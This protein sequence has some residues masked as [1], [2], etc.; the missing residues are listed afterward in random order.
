MNQELAMPGLG[1][2][3][4]AMG[5][6]DNPFPVVPDARHYF[7]T[8][9]LRGIA[10]EVLFAISQRKGFVVV[11]GDV[12]VGKTT[13]SRYLIRRLDGEQYR[14]ALI[15]NSNL[16]EEDLIDAILRDFELA[17]VSGEGLQA[18]LD[19]LNAFFLAQ[20]AEGRNCVVIID[21]AQNL[22]V[23]SLEALRLLSNLETESEKLVQILLVGQDE[24][25]A[26]LGLDV[27]RQLRSR[28]VLWRELRPF[29]RADLD[30]YIHERLCGE[31]VQGD[32]RIAPAALKRVYGYS[33]GNLRRTNLL[34]DRALLGLLSIRSNIIDGRLVEACIADIEGTPSASRRG[35]RFALVATAML[36][37]VG[38]LAY[39]AASSIE[40]EALISSAP[41]AVAVAAPTVA[42][43]DIRQPDDAERW[44]DYLRR[45]QIEASHA[46]TWPLVARH[47]LRALA[48][49][50]ETGSGYRVSVLPASLLR[51]AELL[52]GYDLPARDGAGGLRLFIWQPLID[53]REFRVGRVS[54]AI[55]Q[56]Q[57]RLAEQGYYST[58]VDGV[59]GVRTVQALMRFQMDMG[60]P[61]TGVVDDATLLALNHPGVFSG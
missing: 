52:P 29:T 21:D 35:P 12:G 41:P 40:A 31:Q 42:A 11:S 15:L 54:A 30:A 36:A 16:Q 57:Q 53:V 51:G 26:T 38:S 6:A 56:L 7:M 2:H 10:H 58:A 3:L 9:A 18:R 27:L 20:R 17:V 25:K 24:L 55:R 60:I 14:F 61:A 47:E 59:V 8:E 22:S 28:V 44:R 49:R 19:R 39:L 50:L 37:I 45:F 13:L 4:A 46:D 1:Q 23:R 34:L 32:Y 33:G 5:F 43:T 48:Q